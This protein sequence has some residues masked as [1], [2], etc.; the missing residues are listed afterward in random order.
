[1]STQRYT[2]PSRAGR[3]DHV[4]A[5]VIIA[6]FNRR[7]LLA[8]VLQALAEQTRPSADF[9]VLVVDDGS[10]DGTCDWVTAQ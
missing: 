10:S 9:E 1:M 7:R 5:S 6:T 3:R 8:K 4:P 2:R